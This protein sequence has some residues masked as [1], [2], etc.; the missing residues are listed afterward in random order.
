M[1]VITVC[2]CECVNTMTDFEPLL[3]TLLLQRDS[4]RQCT[5]V[6]SILYYALPSTFVN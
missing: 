5:L 2:V 4:V 3:R 6:V 1:R